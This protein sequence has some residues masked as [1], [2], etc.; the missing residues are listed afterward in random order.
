M[1]DKEISEIFNIDIWELKK[2]YNQNKAIKNIINNDFKIVYSFNIGSSK[3]NIK[4]YISSLDKLNSFI[5]ISKALFFKSNIE[6][7]HYINEI[8]NIKN[9]NNIF[10]DSFILDKKFKLN[11]IEQKKHILNILYD[12]SDFNS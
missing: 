2:S 5:N 9:D 10:I 4:F 6:I 12:K 1:L 11:S 7:I 8:N 3:R